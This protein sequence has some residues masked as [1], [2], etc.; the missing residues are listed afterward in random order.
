M[1][2]G[3]WRSVGNSTNGFFHES[4][5]DE[6][7]TAAKL[8]PVA[9]RLKLMESY[10]TAHG[11]VAKVAEMSNWAAPKVESRA[12]GIAFTLSFGS[13]VAMVVEVADTPLGIKIENVWAAADVGRA[14]DPDIIKAQ[15]SSAAIFGLSAA[16]NQEITFADGMV[17]QKNF[18]DF[19]AMR[20]WQCP[21]FDIAILETAE[22]MGGVGEIG[23]PPA[24][25]ALANA[26]FALT[27]KRIRQLPLSSEVKFA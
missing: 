27:G 20:M 6:I 14:L 12:K 3:F 19:D 22:D 21:K 11:A 9:L 5:M 13:W 25:P 4:F 10:P 16:M 17:E 7:A 26:I 23:T 15:I 24:A 2:V 8:D 18:N 1:P